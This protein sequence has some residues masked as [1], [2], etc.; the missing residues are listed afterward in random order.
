MKKII[1]SIK[2]FNKLNETEYGVLVMDSG[3]FSIYDLKEDIFVGS[4]YSLSEI[5]SFL[6]TDISET[7][8]VGDIV[9][10]G[11]GNYLISEVS[12]DTYCLIEI[13][14][15][16]RFRDPIKIQ[17]L[18]APNTFSYKSFLRIGTVKMKKVFINFEYPK[19]VSG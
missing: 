12:N 9:S 4:S 6:S 14:S 13:F 7:Y 11:Q 3:E 15:G 19:N 5:K 8:E 10:D 1:T 2:R 16:N 17:G 18:L